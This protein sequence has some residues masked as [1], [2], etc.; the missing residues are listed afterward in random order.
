MLEWG[1]RMYGKRQKKRKSLKRSPE[2]ALS[3]L[4]SLARLAPYTFSAL[5]LLLLL[6]LAGC[7]PATEFQDNSE[8]VEPEPLTPSEQTASEQAARWVTRGN[9]ALKA[10]DVKEAI[11]CYE[12]AAQLDPN[13]EDI[14]YNLGIAYSRVGNHQEAIKAYQN[15]LKLMPGYAEAHNNLGNL[16][17]RMGKTNEGLVHLKKAVELNPEYAKAWNNLGTAYG[18]LGDTN[19]AFRCFQR[20]I[21]IDPKNWEA[22]FNLASILLR[23]GDIKAARSN[24]EAV[25]KANPEFLPA[26]KILERLNHLATNLPAATNSTLTNATR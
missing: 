10:G 1:Y 19:E 5:I 22:R 13:D 24:Y 18:I 4:Y 26:K 2:Q 12:Q 23:C 20:A 14:Y 17:F 9:E 8:S 7:R 25:L 15:A 3:R 6:G 21:R 11:R 16:L